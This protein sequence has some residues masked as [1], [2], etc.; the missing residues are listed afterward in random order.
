MIIGLEGDA[1]DSEIGAVLNEA[2]RFGTAPAVSRAGSATVVRL[3][4]SGKGDAGDRL[5]A[6]PQ[7]RGV[8][9]GDLP[10]VLASRDF[11]REDTLVR[12]RD[13]VLGGREV[14]LM[15]GPCAVES[16]DQ[17]FSVAK[18][19]KA[20]GA[21]IL[22]GGA[23]KPRTSPYAFQGLG[24]EGLKLLAEVSRELDLPV[25]TEVMAPEQ[26]DLVARYADMLQ[27]GS[28][29]VQ[30]FPL[31]KAVGR[32]RK[33]VLLKRG[34]ASEIDEFI[35]AAEYI[36]AEGNDQVVL[37]ERGIRTFDS[38]TRFTFDVVAIPLLK[39]LTHL[40]VV[41]DPSHATGMAALV[42]QAA[43]A[44][45]AAGADGLLIESHPDPREAL[46]DGRQAVTPEELAQ[47]A[48]KIR[49][50]AAAVGRG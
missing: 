37:C 47:L 41:G 16:R 17:L 7:V 29:S 5:R 40:P 46:S 6:M 27:I 20:A 44:A 3:P 33:P 11:K 36:L 8:V 43:L 1:T 24:E 35:A 10:Y 32:T 19:V 12:V 22:R 25:V 50:V 18:Q 28:R 9:D 30:N 49:A 2:G 48:P 39:R 21:R 31:L 14:V 13:V 15:A 34:M 42:P 23:F 38:R 45:V 26:V 4:V